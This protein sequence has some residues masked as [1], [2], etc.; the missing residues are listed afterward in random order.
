MKNW[1]LIKFI[2]QT[3]VE[4]TNNGSSTEDLFNSFISLF[5]SQKQSWNSG[6]TG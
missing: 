5:F 3:C 6:L 2:Q 4:A 1:K